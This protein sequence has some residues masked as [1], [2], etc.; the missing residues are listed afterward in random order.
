MIRISRLLTLVAFLSL[1]WGQTTGKII[2]TI[3]SEDGKV[4]PGANI[5]VVGTSIG[6]ASGADG[7]YTI[8]NIPVGAYSL[9]IEYLI[10]FQVPHVLNYVLT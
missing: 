3:T 6:T 4:L 10:H 5:S 9:K 7:D 8:I 1:S 2:G